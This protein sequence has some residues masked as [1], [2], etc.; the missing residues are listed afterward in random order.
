MAGMRFD[1]LKKGWKGLHLSKSR[2]AKG[3]DWLKWD[4]DEDKEAEPSANTLTLN[5][6]MVHCMF[7]NMQQ[8]TL[9]S[10]ERLS[11]AAT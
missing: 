11:K 9:I 8:L 10:I 7:E 4:E 6:P 1:R 2:Q 3:F 5:C